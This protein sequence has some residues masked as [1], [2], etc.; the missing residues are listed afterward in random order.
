MR[1]I[2]IGF[3]NT[4]LALVGAAVPFCLAFASS[5]SPQTFTFQGR[6]LN[7][8]GSA[9][10]NKVVDVTFGVYSPDGGCLLYEEKQTEIDLSAT[11][12]MFSVQVGSATGSVRRTDL[13]PGKTMAQI[14]ANRGTKLRDDDSSSSQT[15]IGGYTTANGDARKL[16][17]VVTP[18]GEASITLSPDLTLSSVPSAF[19]SET[20]QGMGPSQFVQVSGNVSQTTMSA[21]TDRGDASMLHNHDSLYVKIGTNASQNLGSG[22]IYT[23]GTMGIGTSIP[24]ADLSFGGDKDRVLQT[25]RSTVGGRSFSIK[26]GGAASGVA[27]LAGGNLNLFSGVSTGS[28]ASDIEFFTSPAGGAGTSD[29]APTSKLVIK[30]SG[31]VGIGTG[32]GNTPGAQLHVNV[33]AAGTVGLLVQGAVG[34][35]ADLLVLKKGDETN[36]AVFDKDGNLTLSGNLTLPGFPTG[37]L[38]AVT[39][40]YSDTRFATRTLSTAVPEANQVIAWDNVAGQ[41]GGVF[42]LWNGGNHTLKHVI[43]TS[44]YVGIYYSNEDR[45]NIPNLEIADCRIHNFLVYGLV[46]QNG[47][48]LVTNSEISNTSSYSVF[49]NGGK[50][51]FLQST[52]A[53][54]FD[55]SSVQPASRDKN[56]ALMIMN[57]NRV[58]P[59]QTEFRNCIISGNLDNEFSLASR[60]LDQYNG[61]FDHCYIRKPDSLNL[62]K[63][64]TAIRWYNRKDTLFKSIRYNYE[65]KIYFNFMPDSVSPVRAIADP[66]VA[67]Q[68]PLDLNGNNRLTGNKPDIGA[69]QWQPVKK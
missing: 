48:V 22:V 19:S 21:L 38:Q 67:A 64:F 13:D 12:G 20:L 65:K 52:I 27:D 45:N 56:P 26:A 7:E 15:C 43:M 63:Q 36:A 44:G 32:H 53:N 34:Q 69:Y 47:N 59:M 14:F 18:Q 9:P 6:L 30:G 46:V 66:A 68:F 1:Y 41:W 57:L 39:R 58:A 54:Y 10:L 51:T 35:T 61:I 24:S 42:L 33:G 31:L 5:E 2:K 29:N 50:H 16:R 17:V 3:F 62:P 55:N 4:V 60:Y 23:T 37:D 8:E 11:D 28:K 49:L 25:D 40:L